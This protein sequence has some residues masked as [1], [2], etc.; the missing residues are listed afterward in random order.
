ME[1]N[2]HSSTR[3]LARDTHSTEE[4]KT[5]RSMCTAVGT[6]WAQTKNAAS[7]KVRYGITNR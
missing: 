1:I 2:G 5:M 6:I 4:P 7:D 3:M